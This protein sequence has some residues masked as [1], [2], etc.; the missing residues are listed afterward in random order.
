MFYYVS[1]SFWWYDPTAVVVLDCV[2][3]DDSVS[4][5]AVKSLFKPLERIQ[6]YSKKCMK[7]ERLSCGKQG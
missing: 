7:L 3:F 6:D 4:K 2:G 5:I 1:V